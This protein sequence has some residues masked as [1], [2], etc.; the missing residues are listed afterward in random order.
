M[1]VVLLLFACLLQVDSA[2]ILAIFH[3]PC[4]SHHILGSTLLKALA[5]R[6]HD[7]TM[8]SPF[9]FKD[10]MENYT[11]ID[12]T[13]MLEYK[14][15]HIV[16]K[17]V[18]S[19]HST[20]YDKM[21][22]SIKNAEEVVELFLI[23]P[24][25]RKLLNSRKRY[26]L[27]ILNWAMNDA[28]LAIPHHFNVPVIVFSSIGSSLLTNKITRNP[29]PYSYIPNL[30]VNYPNHMSLM[31][32]LNNAFWSIYFEVLDC[33]VNEKIQKKL[34]QKHF[35]NA[36][37]L[38]DLINNVSLVFLNSHY[39]VEGAR[40]YLPNMIEIGGFHVE[41]PEPLKTNLKAFLDAASD[42]FIFFSLGT[43]VKSSHLPKEKLE[44]IVQTFKKL[45][46][47]VLWKFERYFENLPSNVLVDEWFPQTDILA[48]SNIRAF[49]THGGRL[50]TIEA[51]YYGVPIVGIPFF[52]DQE[53][54]IA[55]SVN[56]KYGVK[57]AYE[58][59]SEQS[60]TMSLLEIINNPMYR[61]NAKIKASILRDQPL[62]P[63]DNAVYWV[64]YVIKHKGAS[65]L[66]ASATKLNWFE[67]MLID[68]TI[69]VITLVLLL[70]ISVYFA[71][72]CII[73]LLKHMYSKQSK[74]VKQGKKRN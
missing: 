40:P 7:V 53:Y 54:N 68:V 61:N 22:F 46:V 18:A 5:R 9:P 41:E 15:N 47:K 28:L 33:F 51:A 2:N 27:I 70:F 57:V 50:S 11:D 48:H 6:G 17:F 65:H 34:L 3:F 36:P 55:D 20:M 32:R 45:E 13:G 23:N 16:P 35:P 19:H 12:I 62:K 71:F 29:A 56:N 8:V 44:N 67:Y 43:N 42:G 26:D 4:K 39:S 1:K 14:E 69:I 73:N 59:L 31:Q 49:V 58:E 64:E 21:T 66:Q 63:L 38:Q 72:K 60:L 37:P 30:F 24:N 10:P 52:S 74:K 25:I